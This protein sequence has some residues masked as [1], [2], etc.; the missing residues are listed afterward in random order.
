MENMGLGND[1][2]NYS[3]EDFYSDEG[4]DSPN[5][6]DHQDRDDDAFAFEKEQQDEGLNQIV[7]YYQKYLGREEDE[8]ESGNFDDYQPSESFKQEQARI[9]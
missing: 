5:K 6:R 9:Q 7:N 8:D 2:D 3:D 4:G 1:S